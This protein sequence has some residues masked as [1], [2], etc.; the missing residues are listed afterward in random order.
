MQAKTKANEAYLQ[1]YGPI[2]EECLRLA[3][4]ESVIVKPRFHLG[5]RISA[6]RKE[7][8]GISNEKGWTGA[9][10]AFM[11]DLQS[12]LGLGQTTVYNAIAF[13]DMFESYDQFARQHFDIKR[14]THRTKGSF[15][16]GLKSPP[17][18]KREKA[19]VPGRDLTWEEVTLYVL[20][21]KS[22]DKNAEGKPTETSQ[23]QKQSPSQGA[24][25]EPWMNFAIQLPLETLKAFRQIAAQNGTSPEALLASWVQGYIAQYHQS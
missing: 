22:R 20:P 9:L 8:E 25:S 3:K 17:K 18:S 6:A 5:K 4:K 1:W 21:K 24:K 11:L 14:V 7:L 23:S 2:L 16:A 13:A 15:Q 19:S 10:G 12:D